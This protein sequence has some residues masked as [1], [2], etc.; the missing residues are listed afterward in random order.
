[1]LWFDV[2]VSQSVLFVLGGGGRVCEFSG[3]RRYGSALMSSRLISFLGM[4]VSFILFGFVVRFAVGMYRLFALIRWFVERV[5]SLR[6]CCSI[7]GE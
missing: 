7:G 5:G 4:G 2:I 1:M 6:C 3:F